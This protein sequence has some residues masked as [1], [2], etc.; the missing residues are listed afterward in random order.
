MLSDES[1]VRKEGPGLSPLAKIFFNTAGTICVALGV[2]GIF[3][4]LLPTTPFLLL[5]SAC[6]V[7]GS[8]R[9]HAMLHSHPHLGPY[10]RNFRDHRG[11]P[12][13]AKVYTL[14]LLWASILLSV[15]LMKYAALRVLLVVI[16]LCTSTYILRLR[17]LEIE[18]R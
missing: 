1:A 17:T 13:R 11:M 16:A 4:P 8:D 18:N 10:I 5:A 9:L 14:V 6:Y 7:R 15:F 3:L 12:K 2:A